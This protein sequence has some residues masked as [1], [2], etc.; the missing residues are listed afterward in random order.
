MNPKHVT[1]LDLSEALFEAGITKDYESEFVWIQPLPDR[2]SMEF[3][4]C[5][6]TGTSGGYPALLLSELLGILPKELA[7]FDGEASQLQFGIVRKTDTWEAGYFHQKT[8]FG[9]TAMD[10]L[11]YLT[12]YLLREGKFNKPTL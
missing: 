10:A 9:N 1:S 7:L 5:H 8:F 12:D 6:R 11:S 2:I 4:V 3:K